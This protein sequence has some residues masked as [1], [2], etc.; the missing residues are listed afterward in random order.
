[1]SAATAYT[2]PFHHHHHHQY[3]LILTRFALAAYCL[4]SRRHAINTFAITTPER[5]HNINI[6]RHSVIHTRTD[7][8]A[9]QFAPLAL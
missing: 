2:R 1:M 7:H 3:G 6:L 9:E 8:G 4:R 5:Y